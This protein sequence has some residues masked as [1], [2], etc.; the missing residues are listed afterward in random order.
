MVDVSQVMIDNTIICQIHV[1]RLTIPLRN[2]LSCNYS[3]TE[4]LVLLTMKLELLSPLLSDNVFI[5]NQ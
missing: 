2:E 5:M 4:I 3:Y 1:S